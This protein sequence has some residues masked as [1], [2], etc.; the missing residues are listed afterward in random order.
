MQKILLPL[1]F[2]V[3]LVNLALTVNLY[4]REAVVADSAQPGI[5]RVVATEWGQRAVSL[6]NAGNDEGLYRLFHPDAK[7]KVSQQQLHEQLIQLR[8]LFGDIDEW[9]FRQAVKNGERND[10]AYY[11]LTYSARVNAQATRNGKLVLSVVKT[12]DDIQL[13]GFRLNAAQRLE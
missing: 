2:I 8:A 5:S 1:I 3:C 4:Q 12:G 10:E 6:Y 9:S 13:Y 7:V 11:Q